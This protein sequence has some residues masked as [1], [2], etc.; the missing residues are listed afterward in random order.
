MISN[1]KKVAFS[2]AI[3][4]GEVLKKKFE[5]FS[6]NKVR[7]KS[8]HEVITDADL[9]SEKAIIRVIK[10]NF[11]EHRIL[12]EESGD[13]KK[14]SDYL[15][16]IDPLDGTTNFSFHSPMWGVSIGL[17]KRTKSDYELIVG[18]GTAPML[19]E[20]YVAEKN[21]GAYV[22][23]NGKKKKM[24]V[25]VFDK[26]K[27]INTYCHGYRRKDIEKA[28]KYN[29]YQ[30]IY[31]LDCRQLGCAVIELAFVASGR[32]ESIFIPGANSWDVAA[33]VLWV[34]E[35]GGIASDLHGDDWSLKSADMLASNVVLH[36]KLLNIINHKAV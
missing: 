9:A 2:A 34:R 17:A 11:P 25:S 15:W 10:K 23:A 4:A 14:D 35:A 13:N 22:I 31:G 6:R 1:Y 7:L 27:I 18:V 30:K 8:H 33:G 28:L 19:G 20:F 26:G 12:S 32:I 5:K 36:K 21:K 29:Y 24:G 16:I 3:E